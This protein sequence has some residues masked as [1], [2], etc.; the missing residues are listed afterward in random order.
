MADTGVATSL[1]SVDPAVRPVIAGYLDDLDSRLP[2]CGR[3]VRSAIIAEVGD[4]LIDTVTAKAAAG[5]EPTDAAQATVVEFGSPRVLA[6]GFAAELAGASANRVGLLLLATG[7]VI[8]SI[9]VGAFAARSGIGWW[10]QLPALWSTMP[11]YVLI[12]AV[13]VPAAMLSATA[14]TG[15][16]HGRVRLH[17]RRAAGAAMIAAASCVVADSVLLVAWATSAE[18][19]WTVLAWTACAISLVR[20]SCAGLAARRCA[21]LRA[22]AG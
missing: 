1:E 9:W 22:A 19:Q 8:G 21:M 2:P 5:M 7:P 18:S 11:V 16:L 3:S 17:G 10:Q 4:G 12:L 15:R 6:H 13:A 20:L 14:G